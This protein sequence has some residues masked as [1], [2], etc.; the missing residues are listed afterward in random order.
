MSWFSLGLGLEHG[1]VREGSDDWRAARNHF[2]AT[3]LVPVARRLLHYSIC[4]RTRVVQKPLNHRGELGGGVCLELPLAI[5]EQ[6]SDESRGNQACLVAK[7]QQSGSRCRLTATFDLGRSS[8]LRSRWTALQV[9]FSERNVRVC[10]LLTLPNCL[11]DP[12]DSSFRPNGP[13][14]ASPVAPERPSP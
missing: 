7:L 4:C 10:F 8:R 13:S 2:P 9:F 5:Q 1:F 3:G 14:D 6:P 12:N 11:C